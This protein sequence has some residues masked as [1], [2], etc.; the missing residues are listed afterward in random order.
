MNRII[1]HYIAGQHQA[2]SGTRTTPVFNPATGR[3]QAE[4]VLAE[5][6]DVDAVVAA[7]SAAFPAWSD[8]APLRRARILFKFKMLLEARQDELAALISSEHGKVHAD[9]LGEVTRG[10]EVVEF[11]CGIPQLLKGEYTEQVGRGIDAWTMRQSLGV[12]AG[13]TPFN[14]PAMVPMWMFPV[15]IACGNTFVLKPSERDPSAALFIA[16]LLEEAGLPPGVFNVLQ[17]DKLAVDGLLTHPD[18][19]AVSFVGSTPIA[20]Y[21]YEMIVLSIPLKRV[22]PGVKDGTLQ[23]E[24]LEKLKTMTAKKE[25]KEKN[26]ENKQQQNQENI[27]PRWDKLKQ[28]LTDK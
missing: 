4:V 6:A 22:H 9:A 23:S 12:V 16:A 8:T 25:V 2:G 19:Q 27:D 3:V 10:L 24:A 28:L 21:I 7:A 11:A 14:F 18:V 15:A 1:S 17:G 26:K 13:I 5:Q 20:Q